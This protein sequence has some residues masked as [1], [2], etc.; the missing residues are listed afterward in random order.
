MTMNNEMINA[1]NT[2]RL[3]YGNSIPKK[4]NSNE[5]RKFALS[6]FE[7]ARQVHPDVKVRI[8]SHAP[9]ASADGDYINLPQLYF[10]EKFYRQFGVDDNE[11]LV[12][13]ALTVINGSQIHEA[14][15]MVWS[16]CNL[17][18]FAKLLSDGEDIYKENS[19]FLSI[20]NIVEDIYIEQRGRE[21]YPGLAILVDGKNSILINEHNYQEAISRLKQKD[22]TADDVVHASVSLKNINLRRREDW[23]GFEEIYDLL[24]S[25]R[26][27]SLT[28]FQRANIAREIHKAL[29]AM[30]YVEGTVK[31]GKDYNSVVTGGEDFKIDGDDSVEAILAMLFLGMIFS[32]KY[33]I[34]GK[35]DG[36]SDRKEKLLKSLTKILGITD[37][38]FTELNKE[39]EEEIENVE[40]KMKMIKNELSENLPKP[41]ITQI[42]NLAK[43]GVEEDKSFIRF[44]EKLRYLRQQN[45]TPSVP[46]TTGSKIMK[47]RLAR[48]AIDGKVLS[49]PSVPNETSGEPEI[50]VLIDISGSMVNNDGAKKGENL[51]KS[52]VKAVYGI[53]KSCIANNISIA[54]YAHTTTSGSGYSSIPIIYPIAAYK[55]ILDGVYVE[56]TKSPELKFASAIQVSHGS[57]YDGIALEFVGKQFTERLGT[58]SIIVCSDGTPAGTG[59][60]GDEAKKHTENIAKSIR[61]KGVSVVSLSLVK[62]VVEDNN[63]IY[64]NKNNFEAYGEKLNSTISKIVS[65]LVMRGK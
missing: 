48:I 28:Q 62:D 47:Q 18:E 10:T 61:K 30:I 24:E 32:S 6:N 13:S 34:F 22:V 29:M 3:W 39:L 60:Y 51:I 8:L 45:N 55:M 49:Y 52:T 7:L 43:E 40:Q 14:Y 50:I 56:K 9:S 54:V 12:P 44:G 37:D 19:G 21:E 1:C 36:T 31:L 16:I 35:E 53:Y 2:M 15:H 57:N 38:E 42:P 59:Y 17:V 20:L 25:A 46:L 11:Q 26:S 65:Q 33:D 5:F 63:Q 27:S 64:G 41:K 4:L 23:E 58:K